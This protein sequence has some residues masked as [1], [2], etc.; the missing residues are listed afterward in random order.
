MV[1]LSNFDSAHESF[2][3]DNDFLAE[4]IL[5]LR[6]PVKSLPCKY[7][8]D[9]VGSKLFD[10]ICE[11]P[12]YYPT[13]TELRLMKDA[14]QE[15]ATAIGSNVDLIEYGSGA[16]KKVRYIL[17]ALEMPA[18]YVAVDISREFLVKA[19]QSVAQDYPGIAV[20]A[21]CADFTKPFEL[22][23]DLGTKS[24][25]SVGYF[26]G[27]TIGN[28]T[29]PEAKDFLEACVKTLGP[30]G[31]MLVGVD[32]K[33]DPVTLEAAYNDAAGITKAFNLNILSHINRELSGNFDLQSFCHVAFYNKE[34][35][36]IEMHLE[37]SKKQ[38]VTV[39]GTKFYFEP[40]ERIHTE[41]S[42]KYEI[43]E[44]QTLASSAG[45]VPSKVWT[46][47]NELFS[48]HFLQI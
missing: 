12:E 47:D 36:R 28:F 19:S 21:V 14:A 4:V 2:V 10:S 24:K 48:V 22:P 39:S 32:L 6:G 15:I 43:D 37:S 7:F 29:R 3:A 31:G 9:E 44:F 30:G 20:H 23:N 27:S 16:S 33:K 26:P 18:S 40:G 25:R 1:S 8:Y 34:L 38:C 13:R 46:D 45:F 35:G 11:S 42:Y 5:G 17:D 41:N